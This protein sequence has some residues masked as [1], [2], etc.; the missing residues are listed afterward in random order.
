MSK[1]E[2]MIIAIDFDGTIVTHEYPEIGRPVP[3]AI[4]TMKEFIARGDK[5]ILWTMRSGESLDDAVR[6]CENN[7]IIFWGINEN[8]EQHKWTSSPKAYAHVYID[9][10]M[11]NAHLIYDTDNILDRGYLDWFVVRHNLIAP[12]L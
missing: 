3:G 4:E 12:S 11:V 6:Y 8:P 5:L 2:P 9:D 7:G 10:A 1:N